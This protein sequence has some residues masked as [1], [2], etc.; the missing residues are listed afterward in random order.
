[1]HVQERAACTQSVQVVGSW[2]AVLVE[3][4]LSATRVFFTKRHPNH[5]VEPRDGPCRPRELA[6]F[7]I[8]KSPSRCELVIYAPA[9]HSLLRTVFCIFRC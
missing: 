4:G 8:S 9:T 6:V 2:L 5:A 1:M 3:A 7:T